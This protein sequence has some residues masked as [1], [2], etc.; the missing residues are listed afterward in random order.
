M[1]INLKQILQKAVECDASDIF[2]VA[3]LP[4]TYKV[5]GQQLRLEEEGRW[6]PQDTLDFAS[7]I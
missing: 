7:G 6:T 2:V 5:N 4:L 1:E 3:G